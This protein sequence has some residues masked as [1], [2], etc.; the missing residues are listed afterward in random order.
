MSQIGSIALNKD[1]A[2]SSEQQAQLK[3][4]QPAPWLLPKLVKTQQYWLVLAVVAGLLA[5]AAM[6]GQWLALAML[7][8]QAIT[9]KQPLL[10]LWPW[11]SVFGLALLLRTVLLN[12]QDRLSQRASLQARALLRQWLLNAWAKR[13]AV[14]NMQQSPAL[15]ATQLLEDVESTDGYFSRFWPQQFL[16]ILSPLLILLIVA[17]LNWVAALILLISA[18]LIPLFMVLVG[19]GAKTLNTKFILQRQRLA[20]HF[21]DRVRHLTM[22]KLFGAERMLAEEVQQRSERYRMIVMKTLRVA[23]LSSAVLEFFASVAIASVAV[24]IGF[25]LLGAIS[26]G[27]ADELTLFSALFILLLSPEF[28]QPLRNLSQFYHDRAAAQAAA[29]SLS[30]LIPHAETDIAAAASV[31]C[32]LASQPVPDVISDD[33]LQVQQLTFGYHRSLQPAVNFSLRRGQCLV[34]SGPSGTGKTT[35]LHTLAGL[36][37]A[38]SGQVQLLGQPVASTPVAYLPQR[39]W[40]IAGSWADNI[41][42]LA[43]EATDGQIEQVL[44]ILGLEPLIQS[45]PAGIYSLLSDHGDGLSGGQLQRLALARLLLCNAPLVLLDEP[46]ASLDQQSRQLVLNALA[47]LKPRVMLVIVS[48]DPDVQ[49]FADQTLGFRELEQLI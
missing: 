6:V 3:R 16:A 43:P 46:T 27:P 40:I 19:M 26:W 2:V 9:A 15:L 7:V 29:A 33:T 48:H 11:A 30:E 24:Y 1:K 10:S 44:T 22:L 41:R 23:F 31:E 14:V 25:A 39:P 37:P 35:C 45:H 18:P 4:P 34:L 42:L 32:E 21:L 28:F 38:L 13:S 5:T 47:E 49:V 20:G 36:L 12:G 17:L 8:S